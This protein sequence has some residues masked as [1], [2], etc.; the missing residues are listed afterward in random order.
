[1]EKLYDVQ[2]GDIVV[3]KKSPN[4]IGKIL[5][6]QSYDVYIIKWYFPENTIYETVHISN[7]IVA[8]LPVS[9]V[10]KCKTEQLYDPQIGDHVV[11]KKSPNIIGQIVDEEGDNYLIRWS[12]SYETIHISE[13]IVT[14]LPVS[15]GQKLAELSYEIECLYDAQ[16][17]DVVVKKYLHEV[18]DTFLSPIR[19]RRKEF[20]QNKDEVMKVILEGTKKTREVAEQTLQEVREVMHLDYKM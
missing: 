6:E 4:T 16:I 14:N 19:Q 8:K 9:E 2:I 13:L 10:K 20:A 11:E 3:E 1:M 17:G 15:E 5:D 12:R 18:L 7:F